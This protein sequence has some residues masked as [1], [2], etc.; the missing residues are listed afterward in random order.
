MRSGAG[1]GPGHVVGRF[2]YAAPASGEP[3]EARSATPMHH[4]HLPRPRALRPRGPRVFRSLAALL[5]G[6]LTLWIAHSGQSS[7]AETA[8]A[9]SNRPD[10]LLITV[11]DMSAD[12]VGVFGS[13]VAG[14]TPRIDALAR[15]GMRF[16]HAHVQT[17]SCMPSR[18]VILSGLSP[19]TSGVEGFF[20]V[21]SPSPPRLS[22]WLGEAGYFTAIRG[23][24]EDSS[25]FHPY[26][27][28]DLVVDPLGR[29]RRLKKNAASYGEFVRSAIAASREA[30]KPFFL[31]VNI[32]DPHKP[33]YKGPD[34]KNPP[35]RVFGPDEIAVPA[36]LPDLPEVREE[37]ARYTSSVRRADDCVG[38]VLDGLGASGAASSTV[39]AFLSDHGMPF[40]FAKTQLYRQSTRTPLVVRWPGVVGAGGV[41]SR[42]MVSSLDL[43]PTLLEAAGLPRPAELQGR[44]LVPLLKGS[45]S[46]ERSRVFKQHDE[47]SGGGRRPMRAVQTGRWLYIWN[48]WAN[49][50]RRIRSATQGMASY[51]AMQRLAESDPA[52]RERLR[53]FEYRTPEELYDM[54]SDPDSMVNRIDDPTVAGVAAELR[55]ALEAWMART[56][57]PLLEVYRRREDA[58]AVE[59]F[60]ARA[61]REASERHRRL[62]EA[63]KAERDAR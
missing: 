16:E 60:V 45:A 39:V 30:G 17:A 18:N 4:G 13:P 51:Q 40:P 38:A 9:A 24:V 47:N 35:S 55:S 48:P 50:E 1:P 23:K 10:I 33:F 36:F 5:T 3:R 44:S 63:R 52:A 49:G 62:K 34:D 2:G 12:L 28:W 54:R 21:R 58:A 27:G 6:L 29:E 26:P 43:A 53:L 8:E 7:A 61:E 31:L 56:G 15:E 11:D 22:D 59:A 37:L 42:H 20:P 57:D 14:T 25:P 32:S 41:D 19:H 46:P